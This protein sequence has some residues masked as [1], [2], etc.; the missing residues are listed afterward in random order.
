M[1][2]IDWSNRL[3]AVVVNQT[4]VTFRGDQ[5][6]SSSETFGIS[7]AN[8]YPSLTP[9]W[10]VIH[11]KRFAKSSSSDL[12]IGNLTAGNGYRFHL[13][14]AIGRITQ[15]GDQRPYSDSFWIFFC[16]GKSTYFVRESSRFIRREHALFVKTVRFNEIDDILLL[17]SQS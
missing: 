17:S 10:S 9:M 2:S 4:S 7:Y 3:T 12:T 11:N 1:P 13:V 14:S 6:N 8:Y 5:I 15:C 16:T